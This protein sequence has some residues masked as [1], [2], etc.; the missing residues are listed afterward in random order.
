LESEVER[1]RSTERQLRDFL[2][3]ATEAIHQVG[4]DG[5][6]LWA[7]QAEL[8][9]LGYSANEYIGRSITEVHA[10]A[11]V[12][13]DI[14][15]RLKRGEKLINYKA[16]LRHKNGSL[17][18][19]EINSSVT[20]EE[21]RFAY[22][23]CFTRDVTDRVNA[24]TT[25]QL[26]SAIVESSDDAI[27]S[28]N[29]DGIIMSWNR[30]AE[31]IFGYA[32]E[33]V[34][35]KSITILIPEDR[36]NE[37]PRILEQIRSGARI[38]HFETVRRRKDGT[39][40]NISLTISPVKNAAGQVIGASKVARDI[41]DR[42]RAKEKLEK[43][44][45]QRTAALRDVV[46]ELESFSYSI[47]HDMRAPL[48]AMQGYARIL[49][50]DYALVLSIEGRDF[51]QRIAT[52]A[53]RLDSL[54]MDVLQYSRITRGEMPLEK[55]DLEQLAN[56]IVESYPQLRMHRGLITIESPIP[57]VTGNGAALTQI[58]SNFLSNAVK[59]TRPNVMPEIRVRGE[60]SGS[61]VRL[62]VEDNGIG[63]SE[64]GRKKIFHMFQ[65]L[66]PSSTFEGTGIGLVIAR[67][68]VERMGGKVGV[69][70]ELGK[71]SRFWI[72]LK[73]AD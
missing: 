35:G 64:E 49:Q 41:T 22:T 70:S 18:F 7:N 36:L 46:A 28:K 38:D 24:D 54:I 17:R 55:V 6:I 14:L 19:V 66:N 9:L 21:G 39:L 31:R 44:V 51:L 32:A 11:P 65:R 71:G 52:A 12:I 34:I 15:E 42:I 59:F 73:R 48:R 20:F 61:L 63:I 40:L 5:K 26:L 25:H 10:D 58:L 62:Y 56:E 30:G 1:R 2:E 53:A 72:E 33:E 27:I 47:A 13:A 4:A 3:N 16:R 68:A 29:L 60:K 43:L 45:T 57:A 37:E 69:E 8:D 50:E 67:K 23:K